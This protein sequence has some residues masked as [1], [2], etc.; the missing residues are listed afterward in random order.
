MIW[1]VCFFSEHKKS[2]YL[3]TFLLI[4]TL[5]YAIKSSNFERRG[6]TRKKSLNW[7]ANIDFTITLW[8]ND[9]ESFTEN[10]ST[11]PMFPSVLSNAFKVKRNSENWSR[12][13]SFAGGKKEWTMIDKKE[14]PPAKKKKKEW[15]IDDCKIH[16]WRITSSE[17]KSNEE[18]DKEPGGKRVS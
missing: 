4:W 9:V 13:K 12:L 1:K 11:F 8:H 6:S 10:T 3:S 14:S 15:T 5:W 18:M 2:I 16:G 17:W 7:K